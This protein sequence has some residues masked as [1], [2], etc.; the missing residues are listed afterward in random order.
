M[1]NKN[2]DNLFYT[3][4]TIIM[5]I[6]LALIMAFIGITINVDNRDIKKCEKDNIEVEYSN[7]RTNKQLTL[8]EVTE[9]YGKL[10]NEKELDL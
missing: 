5:L 8:E 9:A 3:M 6:M 7:F 4:S 1:K 10:N 2:M